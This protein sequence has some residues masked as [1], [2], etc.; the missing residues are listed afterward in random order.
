MDYKE[1]LIGFIAGTVPGVVPL[2]RRTKKDSDAILLELIQVLRAEIERV[3]IKA[4]K[5]DI[6]LTEVKDAY[7]KLQ[8]EYDALLKKYN[9]LKTDFTNYKNKQA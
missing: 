9:Q 1:M 7:Q 2:F 6:E 8:N 3:R 4:D 5:T